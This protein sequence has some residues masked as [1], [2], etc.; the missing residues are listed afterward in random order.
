MLI[1][2]RQFSS[3]FI[4]TAQTYRISIN[5]RNI[6]YFRIASF[7][8]DIIVMPLTRALQTKVLYLYLS[9]LKKRITVF[10]LRY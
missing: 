1:N 9:C 10:R 6:F 8:I 2:R 3:T 4:Y 7:H 5:F